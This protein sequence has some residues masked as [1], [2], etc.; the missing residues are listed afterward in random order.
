[1]HIKAGRIIIA[2]IIIE[3]IA[4]LGLILIVALFGPGD[5]QAAQARQAQPEPQGIPLQGRYT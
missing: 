5:P 3:V 1:M 4:I 2:S